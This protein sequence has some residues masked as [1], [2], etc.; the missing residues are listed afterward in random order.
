MVGKLQPRPARLLTSASPSPQTLWPPWRM[1]NLSYR[2]H[3]RGGDLCE[4]AGAGH[5]RRTAFALLP[6]TLLDDKDGAFRTC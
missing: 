3:E 4:D 1:L 6:Y 5:R 2:A